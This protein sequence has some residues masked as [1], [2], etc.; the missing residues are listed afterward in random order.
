L[1]WYSPI[2]WRGFINP[3]STFNLSIVLREQYQGEIGSSDFDDPFTQEEKIGKGGEPK[4]NQ[5]YPY[6]EPVRD[7]DYSEFI[8]ED[9]RREAQR[10]YTESRLEGF[11]I[12]PGY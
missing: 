4:P 6:Q 12:W 9:T 5:R 11:S 7:R 3:S 1:I 10:E 2:R 8:G